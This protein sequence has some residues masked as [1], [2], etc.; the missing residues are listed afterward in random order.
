MSSAYHY[1]P[2]FMDIRIRPPK[3]GERVEDQVRADAE[4]DVYKLKPGQVRCEHPDCLRPAEAKCP[5]GR[6]LAN[7]FYQ[8]CQTHAADYNK[9]WNFF[10]GMSQGDVSRFQAEAL[11]GHRPTWPLRASNKS[12]E[13]ATAKLNPKMSPFDLFDRQ[14][15][16]PVREERPK[17]EPQRHLGR[18][19]RQAL[20]DLGLGVAADKAEIAAR[21]KELLKRLHPDSNGGD[22]STEAKLQ[23]VIKAYKILKKQNLA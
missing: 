14:G 10:E 20:S 18:L 12:R 23:V 2:K 17:A 1:R 8:F 9:N 3:P 19:E 7:E 6:G 22:R 21:Y 11:T 4:E 13:A 16:G 15:G 5:K